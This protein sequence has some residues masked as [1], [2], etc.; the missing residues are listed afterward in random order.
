[1]LTLKYHSF[2][3]P[4]FLCSISLCFVFL[5]HSSDTSEDRGRCWTGLEESSSGSSCLHCYRCSFDVSIATMIHIKI[6]SSARMPS[7]SL[8]ISSFL[9]FSLHLFFSLFLSPSLLFSN[10]PYLYLFFSL[11]LSTLSPFSLLFPK[12]LFLSIALAL[13]L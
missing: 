13:S 6:H 8:S 5:F 2:L 11:S 4:S 3:S 12:S 1:M 9:Y 7:L 10:S